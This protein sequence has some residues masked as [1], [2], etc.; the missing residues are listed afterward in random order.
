MIRMIRMTRSIRSTRTPSLAVLAILAATPIQITA[1]AQDAETAA[2]FGFDA[3]EVVPVG[4]NA[5]PLL[6]TDLDADGLEDLLVVNNHKSRIEFLRQR[7]DAVPGEPEAPRRANELPEHWRFERIEIPVNFEVGAIRTVDVDGD[8]ML[9]IVA[10]GR[11]Q[12]IHRYPHP[13]PPE[14]RLP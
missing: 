14:F 2:H 11:P 13:P 10:G 8:G 5:G 4:P 9:D 6:S 1:T 7:A 12:S 3:L